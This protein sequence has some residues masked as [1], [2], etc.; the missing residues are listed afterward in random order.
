[1]DSR[2][3]L[4]MVRK[5]REIEQKEKSIEEA[6]LHLSIQRDIEQERKTSKR[7]REVEWILHG[8]KYLE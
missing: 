4:K 2:L 7:E 6:E 5:L 3:M 8:G 1:V